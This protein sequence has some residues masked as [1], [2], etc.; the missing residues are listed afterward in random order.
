[1]NNYFKYLPVSK[2]F[3]SWGIYVLN[4]GRTIIG[5]NQHYPSHNHP[6]DHYFNWESGRILDEYQI[7]YITSGHGIFEST[8][9][10]II[11]IE[12]GSILFLFPYEW[13]RFKPAQEEGWEENW[14]GLN[15]KLINKLIK[16]NFLSKANPILK[17]G[18]QE[19]I[20]ALYEEIILLV[21]HEHPGYQAQVSG[22]ALHLIGMVYSF[23]RQKTLALNTT[24]DDLIKQAIQKIRNHIYST[25]TIAELS[26][27]M[28][29]SYSAFRKA[30]KQ[31]T[32]LAPNQYLLH[33]KIDKAKSLLSM[34][35]KSIKEIAFELGFESPSYFSKIFKI[36]TKISPEKFRK[37]TN[38]EIL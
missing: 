17:I 6:S 16:N 28:N 32:G 5:I 11:Q 27:E 2:E 8:S 22:A 18:I 34:S 1:M 25:L 13:H 37:S 7:I 38:P 9:A 30:F 29:M 35:T 3:K 19:Q 33:L 31:Y 15:G 24:N 12:P 23:Y 14:I 10:G 21:K 26:Q 20:L 4:A 36:K